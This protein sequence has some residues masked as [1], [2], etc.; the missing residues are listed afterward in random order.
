MR[1]LVLEHPGALIAVVGIGAGVVEHAPAASASE[2]IAGRMTLTHISLK[3]LAQLDIDHPSAGRVQFA[4]VTVGFVSER[5]IHIEQVV[6][7]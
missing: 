7:R 2:A 1:T 4:E 6:D 5:R 3:S